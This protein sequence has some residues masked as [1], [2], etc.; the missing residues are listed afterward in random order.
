MNSDIKFY[1]ALFRRR[2]PVMLV[3]FVLGLGVG[4]GLALTLPAKYEAN[5][6]LLV[7]NAQIPE[8][9]FVSTVQTS[10]DKQLQVIEQR[11]MT[12]ANMIDVANKFDVFGTYPNMDPNEIFATMSEMTTISVIAGNSRRN[13]LMTISFESGDPNKAAD[14]VNELVTLV[15]SKSAEIRQSEAGETAEFFESEVRRLS[16]ELS[17]KSAAIVAF[18]E[19]NKNA[20]PEEL[21]YRLERQGQLQERLNLAARDRAALNEQRNRLMAVGTATGVQPPALTPQQQQLQALQNELNSALSIYSESNPRVKMLRAQIQSLKASIT[22]GEEAGPADDPMQTMVDL[23][24][25]EID[26]RIEFLDQD[27]ARAEDEL[28]ELRIAIEKT[29]QNAIRLEA[30]ER[31]YER[32]QGQYDSAVQSLAQAKVGES[33]EYQ[34][35]GERI[36]VIER[37]IPPSLPSSP[38]RKLVAGGGLLLGA[39][40]AAVFFVLMELL[41]RTIRRPVDLTRGLGIQPLATIP[42]IERESVRR[43]RR[44]LVTITL[45]AVLVAIPV[46]LW[47]VHTYYLPLDL[48]AEIALE[49]LGL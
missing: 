10:A 48:L 14:V 21:D 13:T 45:I 7:E 22:P 16:D 43:R 9:M 31:D 15:E 37:A 1:F 28:R 23:Q 3:I 26:S 42:Y 25:A 40:L 8:E 17:E 38:N 5:A 12:R 39:A 36:T 6:R 34:G 41:N 2:L 18:K 20:L 32:I 24:V 49:R 27:I 46:A 29:P 19:A 33:I 35:R 11:L 47:A 30:L 4:L 44:A